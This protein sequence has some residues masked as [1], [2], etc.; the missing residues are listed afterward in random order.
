MPTNQCK[1]GQPATQ[2][3]IIKGDT[4]ALC[5]KHVQALEKLLGEKLEPLPRKYP[6]P[7]DLL[8]KRSEFVK[9]VSQKAPKK[10]ANLTKTLILT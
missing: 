5:A 1:C 6:K 4:I 2:L 10:T 7:H 9:L 8:N 3:V